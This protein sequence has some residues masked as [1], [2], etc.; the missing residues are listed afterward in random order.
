MSRTHRPNRWNEADRF[1]FA[2]Q[3]L[4]AHTIPPRRNDGPTADEWD[5]LDDDD[6]DA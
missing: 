3:R 6:D 5:E 4:R 2:T 1:A